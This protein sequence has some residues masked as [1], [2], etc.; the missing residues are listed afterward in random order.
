MCFVCLLFWHINVDQ[1]GY[2]TGDG[3]VD[4]IVFLGEH[5][6][7]GCSARWHVE[8]TAEEVNRGE[9]EAFGLVDGGKGEDWWEVGV[10]VGEEGVDGGFEEFD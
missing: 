3:D 5:P 10:V 7:E 2:C 9:F 6:G 4:K 8:V 1:V